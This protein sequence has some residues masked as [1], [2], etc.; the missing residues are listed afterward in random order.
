MAQESPGKAEILNHKVISKKN[1]V[2]GV[3]V[4]WGQFYGI[5]FPKKPNI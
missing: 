1:S 4:F 3:Y 2:S 5:L